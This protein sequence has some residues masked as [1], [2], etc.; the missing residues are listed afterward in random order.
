[1]VQ[2]FFGNFT[3]LTD[4]LSGQGAVGRRW[5]GEARIQGKL[6]AQSFAKLEK[7]SVE[8][9]CWVPGSPKSKDL[10]YRPVCRPLPTQGQT[11]L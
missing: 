4:L 6:G 9:W 3:D 11:N 10:Q 1:M 8:I 7:A 2:F 5:V